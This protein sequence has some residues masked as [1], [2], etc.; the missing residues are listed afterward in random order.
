M[1]RKKRYA[2]PKREFSK[3]V[4][5]TT[6]YGSWAFILF[7]CYEMHIQQTLEPIAYIGAGIVGL[8]SIVIGAY[9]WRAKQKDLA[10]LE[11]EKVKKMT[12][13]RVKHGDNVQPDTITQ[14]SDYE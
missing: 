2:K 13:L 5:T 3:K 12:A 14:V 11:Y 10:D 6:M 8:L 4:V 7:A 9:M 1:K